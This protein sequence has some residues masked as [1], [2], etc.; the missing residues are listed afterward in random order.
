ML[1]Y[2]IILYEDLVEG[3]RAPRE[4]GRVARRLAQYS[5]IIIIITTI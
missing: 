2:Y 3:V 5:I 1:V 4:G